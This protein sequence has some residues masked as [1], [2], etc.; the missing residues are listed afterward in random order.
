V[1]AKAYAI[2]KYQK[3]LD[4]RFPSLLKSFSPDEDQIYNQDVAEDIQTIYFVGSGLIPQGGSE[5]KEKTGQ[6]SGPDGEV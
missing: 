3:K 5:G 2:D 6:E 4:I 1:I